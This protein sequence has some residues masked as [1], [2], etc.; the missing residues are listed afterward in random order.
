[1]SEEEGER[2]ETCSPI[3]DDVKLRS[4]RR[5]SKRKKQL[6]KE[7]EKADKRGVCYLSHIPPKMD[8]LK[9]RQLLSQ[10]GEIQR[11]YLTPES[12]LLP[13]LFKILILLIHNFVSNP[14]FLL[15]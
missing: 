15:L 10:Y 7:A 2:K 9:L 4:E 3:E 14:N 12:N 11:I 13:L 6:M 1:M 8:P 5:K